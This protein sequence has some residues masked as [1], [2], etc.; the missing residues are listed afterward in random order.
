MCVFDILETRRFGHVSLNEMLLDFMTSTTNEILR[1]KEINKYTHIIVLHF[2]YK[3]FL[4]IQ[5]S[6]YIKDGRSSY[7]RNSYH[8]PWRPAVPANGMDNSITGGTR[9]LILKL[10]IRYE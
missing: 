6:K 3:Q 8:R 7:Q 9:H 5:N 1:Y 4:P 10:A 2:F